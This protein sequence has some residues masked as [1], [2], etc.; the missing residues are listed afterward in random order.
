MEDETPLLRFIHHEA[1]AGLILVLAAAVALI[2]TNAGF[3][4]A[5]LL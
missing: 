4:S 1:T 3:A 2:V 5:A